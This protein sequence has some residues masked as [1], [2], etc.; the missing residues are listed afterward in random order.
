MSALFLPPNP[1]VLSPAVNLPTVPYCV[2]I[3]DA[4]V[5]IPIA[6]QPFAHLNPSTENSS[7]VECYSSGTACDRKS[8][9]LSSFCKAHMRKSVDDLLMS[10]HIMAENRATMTNLAYHNAIVAVMQ[11]AVQ[12]EAVLALPRTFHH[13]CKGCIDPN[14][15]AKTPSRPSR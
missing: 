11:H 10:S 14:F 6:S 1:R 15:T 8:W 13:S 3:A 9:Y 2:G 5:P 4:A 7:S 12:S